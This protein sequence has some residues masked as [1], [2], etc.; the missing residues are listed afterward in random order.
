MQGDTVTHWTKG[1]KYTGRF[2][3]DGTILAG[4]WRP[5]EDGS[6]DVTY[7]AIMTRVEI[8]PDR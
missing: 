5:D 6:D 4:G 7:D 2:S 1:S 3:E 8:D